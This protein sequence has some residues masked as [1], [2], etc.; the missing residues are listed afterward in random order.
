VANDIEFPKSHTAVRDNDAS[1]KDFFLHK[2]EHLR[3]RINNNKSINGAQWGLK[4]VS[5]LIKTM[6]KT[7]MQE[8][9]PKQ[10]KKSMRHCLGLDEL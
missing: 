10:Q 6:F 9:R 4:C 2:K 1:T 7:T 8:P 5:H 3:E